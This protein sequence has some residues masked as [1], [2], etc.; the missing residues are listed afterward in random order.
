[1]STALFCASHSPLM[2]CFSK[3]PKEHEAIKDL[4]ARRAT[5]IKKFDPEL[6][7]AFGPDH[8]TSFFRKLAP[9]F[10]IGMASHATGDIGGYAGRLNVPEA[11]GVAC[12]AA[13]PDSDIKVALS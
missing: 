5:E 11:T 3:A 6:G 7:F 12:E 4:F 10:C 2:H 9:P 13:L 1:M 8:Y